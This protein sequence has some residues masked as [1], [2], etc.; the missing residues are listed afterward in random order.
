M[1]PHLRGSP[2]NF[3]INRIGLGHTVFVWDGGSS[4]FTEE[5][6]VFRFDDL[7]VHDEALWICHKFAHMTFPTSSCRPS[8]QGATSTMALVRTQL[9]L[10]IYARLNKNRKIPMNNH[11]AA[12][13]L[14]SWRLK[15]AALT[16]AEAHANAL[17]DRSFPR[18]NGI[19][20]AAEASQSS[21][22]QLA[23]IHSLPLASRR[24]VSPSGS[25]RAE[26]GEDGTGMWARPASRRLLDGAGAGVLTWGRRR[27]SLCA[28]ARPGNL[29]S[30]VE[31][32]SHSL[33]CRFFKKSPK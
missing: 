22:K 13:M 6:D 1:S 25:P 11:M 28:L 9:A 16:C 19:N 26:G 33:P 30:E 14:S 17:L 3:T 20:E 23:R 15:L 8:E 10:C 12:F 29:C 21:S 31:T 24:V 4:G 27:T 2:T 5:I 32:I 7:Q 18:A